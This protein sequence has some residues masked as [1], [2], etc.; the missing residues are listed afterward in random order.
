MDIS[1]GGVCC[2]AS[3]DQAGAA[4]DGNY[5]GVKGGLY[6]ANPQL[7]AGAGEQF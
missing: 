3:H 1:F 7:T 5:A 6:T 2:G 4:A